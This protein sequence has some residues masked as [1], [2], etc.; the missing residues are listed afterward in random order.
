MININ[1]TLDG[2]LG[3]NIASISIL[4]HITKTNDI[5]ISLFGEISNQIIE[6]SHDSYNIDINPPYDGGVIYKSWCGNYDYN[7]WQ[8]L[9]TIGFESTVLGYFNFLFHNIIK[10]PI[11]MSLKYYSTDLPSLYMSRINPSQYDYLIINSDGLSGQ[12]DNNKKDYILTQ[13]LNTLG[14]KGMNVWC[15]KKIP[16]IHHNIKCTTDYNYTLRDIGELSI[17]SNRIIGVGT[18]PMLTCFNPYNIDKSIIVIDDACPH[19]WAGN[20]TITTTLNALKF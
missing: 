5:H 19:V 15:T 1:F 12:C 7:P 3:D 2:H 4:N 10:Y 17:Y 9:N 11:H 13:L 16:N 8:Y 20:D 18:S 6:I 14:S